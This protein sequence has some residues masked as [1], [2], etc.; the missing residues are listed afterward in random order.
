MSA[1]RKST[2]NSGISHAQD[3]VINQKTN[4]IFCGS[5]LFICF[6]I[7][8]L[9]F[10]FLRLI[11]ETTKWHL[12]WLVTSKT[13][14]QDKILILNCLFPSENILNRKP[15]KKINRKYTPILYTLP[16]SL[17]QNTQRQTSAHRVALQLVRKSKLAGAP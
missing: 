6:E 7:T 17:L 3:Y 8:F 10:D 5:V 9:Y 4:C 14:H 12:I 16:L 2:S 15:N 11:L 13:N 1:T